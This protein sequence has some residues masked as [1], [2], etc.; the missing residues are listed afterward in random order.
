MSEI[1]VIIGVFICFN[2]IITSIANILRSIQ[3]LKYNESVID[4][5]N[6]ELNDYWNN[7]K[8]K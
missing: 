3:N 2:K 5:I 6:N 7:E 4:L 1:F 8:K